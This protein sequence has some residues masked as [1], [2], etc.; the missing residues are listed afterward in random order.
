MTK[1]DKRLQEL[2]RRYRHLPPITTV[3]TL[4]DAWPPEGAGKFLAERRGAY[5][6]E[7]MDPSRWHQMT[8]LQRGTILA[9]NAASW[10]RR[11]GPRIPSPIRYI[12]GTDG[13]RLFGARAT[14]LSHAICYV[15]TLKKSHSKAARLLVIALGVALALA[16][17]LPAGEVSVHLAELLFDILSERLCEPPPKSV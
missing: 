2:G 15:Y 8:D 14:S 4:R 9:D 5:R 6:W 7:P 16:A 1:A 13:K 10:L 11:A 3:T 17:G 12:E